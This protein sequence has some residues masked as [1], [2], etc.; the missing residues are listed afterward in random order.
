VKKSNRAICA[1]AA[2]AAAS[3]AV[4]AA[5][6]AGAEPLRAGLSNRLSLGYDSFIDRF[7]ILDDDT[8]D[9]VHDLYA[10]VGNTLSLARGSA[11]ASFSNF[12]RYGNQTVDEF[13]DLDA[14][15][16]PAPAWR[17]DLRGGFRY[18][19]FREGSD[20]AA[21]NDYL[22]GNALVRVRTRLSNRLRAGVRARF[23]LVDFESRNRYDYDYSYRDAG[24]EI[25]AG[26]EYSRMLLVSA[27]LG[28]R[29][30]PD[31]TALGFDRVAVELEARETA[32]DLSLHF[33]LHGDR[34]N[35]R[36]EV[37]SDTWLVNS[38][39][40]AALGTDAG[41][42]VSL[43]AE[44]ELLSYDRPDAIYFDSQFIRG[45]LRT[46]LPAGS[47]ATVFLEPRY[48]GMLC[49]DFAEE[50]YR[51]ISLVIGFDAFGGERHW[52]SA[53]YEPGYR[54]YTAAENDFYSDFFVNRVSV[55]GSVGFA[56]D[57]SVNIFLDHEPERHTRR[58]DDFSITLVSLDITKRF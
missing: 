48:A 19:H 34:R 55:M 28:S 31:T 11:R 12:F 26:A 27:S 56:K 41:R 22:Q 52:V 18:K 24:V 20:Y 54:D 33:G 39:F 17:V 37:R 45:G 10:G 5:A 36:E 47:T 38:R 15:I 42:S 40:E 23:E 57:F 6:A 14:A 53:S 32:G 58:E 44:A 8:A 25:E 4:C 50:R 16:E 21:A 9:A 13:F 30:A 51:E 43:R 35:Y 49:A 46:R 3:L 1:A 2:L 7:T 29:E